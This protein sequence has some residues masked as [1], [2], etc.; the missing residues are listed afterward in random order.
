MTEFVCECGDSECLERIE[1][2]DAEYEK[3]RA[4]PL[5]F[6]VVRGHEIPDV[7]D[8]VVRDDR[9]DVVRKHIEEGVI[10]R[11]TDPRG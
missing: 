9:F 7:E 2:T 8:V 4:D 6:A 10:A 5:L 11:E 3:L 1:L